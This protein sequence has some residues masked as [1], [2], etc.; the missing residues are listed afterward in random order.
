[1]IRIIVNPTAG[2]GR[3]RNVA[4]SLVEHLR[5]RGD[6]C[7]LSETR[8][9]GHALLLAREAV[10]ERPRTVVAA[11]GDGTVHE[12]ANG[13]LL[14]AYEHGRPPPPLAVL[15]IGTG[16]DFAKLIGATRDPHAVADML[17]ASSVR[18]LDAGIVEWREDREYFVNGMGLGVDVEVV[19]QIERL[20]RFRGVTGYLIGAVRALTRY[21]PIELE[22]RIDGALERTRIMMVAVTNGYCIGGGFRMCPAAR[23]DD[24]KL[25]VCV[26]RELGWIGVVR[27]LPRALRGTH[28]GVPGVTI[29]RADAVE[30][31][32]GDGSDLVFQLDGELREPRNTQ[33][34]RIAIVPNA[35]PVV[36]ADGSKRY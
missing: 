9:R 6:S 4:A 24:G 30:V 20:P 31:V 29:T 34:L 26:V 32:S 18:W 33:S 17:R 25:D 8:E 19:R 28:G 5:R 16:N 14:G 23:P 35:L 22:L 12:V 11:G 10:R 15:P 3:A 1:M 36:V 21:R 13:L 2:G 27:T 7:V